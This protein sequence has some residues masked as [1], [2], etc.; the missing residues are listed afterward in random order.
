M[1]PSGRAPKN[2]IVYTP[3]WVVELMLSKVFQ[4]RPF[5]PTSRVLDPACGD[6][7][8]LVPLAKS[9][10]RWA[11]NEE[12][13]SRTTRDILVDAIIGRDIDESALIKCQSQL[14]AI[15]REAGLRITEWNV[16]KADTLLASDSEVIGDKKASHVIGNP[17][18]IRIQDLPVATRRKLQQRFSYC[19]S[20]STDIFLAFFE[21]GQSLL[22]EDGVLAFITS[23]SLFDSA[24]ASEFR[25]VVSAGRLAAEIIDFGYSQ[26]FPDVSTYTAITILSSPH[27]PNPTVELSHVDADTQTSVWTSS[28]P[29]ST[30]QSKRWYVLRDSDTSFVKEV[31]NR[32]PKLGDICS[33]RV[34]LA[35]LRDKIYVN[36]VAS[37]P[38]SADELELVPVTTHSGLIREL[39]IGSL[40]R[41]VKVS[42]LRASDEDQGL[43]ILFPYEKYPNGIAPWSA[44]TQSR[45][46]LAM[47]FLE[48][49]RQELA[50]RGHGVRVWFEYGS[51]QGLGTLYGKKLLVP[52]MTRDGSLYLWSREAWTFYSGYGIFF[53]G[54]IEALAERLA[55]EDFRRYARLAGRALRGGWF[56]MTTTSLSSFSLSEQEWRDLGVS[57]DAIGTQLSLLDSAM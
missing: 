42:K 11:K 29:A 19:Q 31:E 14:L 9:I 3:E 53:S 45:F 18:Y 44:R 46:P 48:E 13:S 51:T 23:R 26:V 41:I 17:P 4:R 25:R 30:F 50:S 35:T 54:D 38:E 22:D 47:Q 56:S 34:G 6:G 40:R 15:S 28:Q 57:F 21:R 36:G 32:G 55:R 37:W 10:I 16:S 12:L 33:I 52:S 1:A 27:H 5:S 7:A 20:G 39:E 8:F 49:H 24:A 2:G 43:A